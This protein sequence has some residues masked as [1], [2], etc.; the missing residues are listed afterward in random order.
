MTQHV[1][2]ACI[3]ADANSC[4]ATPAKVLTLGCCPLRFLLGDLTLLK[5]G[6][7]FVCNSGYPCLQ[8]PSNGSQCEGLTAGSFS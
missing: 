4:Q 3:L 5:T 1:L 6:I 8:H 7:Q 2:P